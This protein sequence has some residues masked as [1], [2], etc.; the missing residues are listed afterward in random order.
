MAKVEIVVN[1]TKQ[2]GEVED[3]TLLVNFLRDS[4]GLT[5]T[6]IGCDT[7]SCGACTIMLDG[8]SVKSCTMFAVQAAGH[9]VTTIEGIGTAAE[10]HP[11][12]EAFWE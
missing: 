2:S 3:R 1:G 9:E 11:M 12:Q 5:G 4:A 7:S 10:L 6:H 8:V